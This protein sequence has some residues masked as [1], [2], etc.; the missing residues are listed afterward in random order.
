MINFCLTGNLS[1][2]DLPHYCALD[3]EAPT[4]SQYHRSRC[5]GYRVAVSLR[6]KVACWPGETRRVYTAHHRRHDLETQFSTGN[7]CHS[8]SR[9]LDP[10]RSRLLCDCSCSSL[11]FR[12]VCTICITGVGRRG[13]WGAVSLLCVMHISGV[14]HILDSPS[15]KRE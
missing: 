15:A 3:L 12:S 4:A 13:F 2:D 14:S 5:S 9:S 10:L 11:A 7:V 1:G 8:R 6:A